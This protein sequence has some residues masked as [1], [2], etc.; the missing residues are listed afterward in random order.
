MHADSNYLEAQVNIEAARATMDNKDL[1]TARVWLMPGF[2]A[3]NDQGEIVTLGRN[4]SDYSAACFSG[5]VYA[6]TVVKFG[7]MLM[8]FITPT[9]AWLKTLN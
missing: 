9:H 6:P 8:V 5:S 1:S 4:G 2:T 3:V 7:P